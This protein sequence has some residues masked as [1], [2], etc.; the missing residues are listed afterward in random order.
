MSGWNNDD[1]LLS[2]SLRVHAASDEVRIHGRPE[3]SASKAK[4][5]KTKQDKLRARSTADGL[6]SRLISSRSRLPLSSLRRPDAL[7]AHA[8]SSLR[9]VSRASRGRSQSGGMDGTWGCAWD[10]RREPEWGRSESKSRGRGWWEDGPAGGSPRSS[11][12][13]GLDPAAH[14]SAAGYSHT[15]QFSGKRCSL[16]SRDAF[17]AKHPRKWT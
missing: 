11:F 13:P 12:E 16:S 6:G 2:A 8:G 4:K 1:L 14:C 3:R 7:D 10:E 17:G 15:G 9:Q 5:N